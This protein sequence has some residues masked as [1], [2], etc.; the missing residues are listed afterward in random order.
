MNYVGKP[1]KRLN[2]SKFITGKSVYIDDLQISSLNA[3]FVRSP[4]AHARVK[5]VDA[6]DALKTKGIV[7]VFTAKDLNPMTS[8]GP[9]P[10][11]TYINQAEWKFVP[12][13]P[14]TEEA[15]Y[16]GDPVAI[17]IGIDKYSVRDAVDKVNV[18][19]EELPSAIALEDALKGEALVHK[20]LGT[21]VGYKKDFSAGNV[22]SA[23]KSADKVIPVEASNTRL[24]PSPMEPRG[25][26][27]RWEGGSLTVW[28]STQIP[29]FAR[30]E[31]SKD[32]GI[33]S[34]RIRVI[35]P[36]VGGA[37]GSK[38]HF[39]AED[40]AV[41]ASSIKLGRTVRWTATRS[42]E[43]ISSNARHNTFKGEVAV[44]RDGTILGIRGDLTVDLGA[45]LTYTEGLQP[46]IIPLMIPGPYKIRDILVRSTAVYTN[47]PPI[48]MY[49]GASRPEATFIIERIMSTVADELHMDDL[50]LREKNMVRADEMP[51]KNPF[52]L[53]YDSG[54]YLSFL[55]E[56]KEKLKYHETLT[57]A[58]AERTKGKRIGVG[59]AFY[60]EISGFGP[61]EYGEIRVDER[62]D[63]TVVTGGTPHGQGT[64]TAI[65]QVVADELQIDIGR[66][67]VVWG[68]TQVVASGMGSYGSRT[69]SI[70]GSAAKSASRQVLEK[71]KYVAAKMLNAD[72]EEVEYSSCEFKYKKEGKSVKWDE[73]AKAAYSG[74]DPGLYASVTLEGDVTYPYGLHMAIV[75][76]DDTGIVRVKE[77]RAYDDIGRVINPALAE[78]QIHG[79]AM[80]GVGQALYEEARIN[81]EGQLAV[82]YA[83]YFVPTIM[84]SPHYTSYFTDRPFPSNYA[85]GTKGVGEAA[86]IVGPAA[87]VRAIENATGKRFNKTPVTPEEVYKSLIK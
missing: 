43:L 31:F 6:S 10:W 35:M 56:A 81:D 28:Y 52:G 51:Y 26:V 69:I 84:E 3:A 54:D 44:K 12:R 24:I 27:S 74:K 7:A 80:Q 86:L 14:L 83:E 39:V 46:A 50:E 60:L 82:S 79:G 19:Y 72:V 59:T 38:A 87:I 65:A 32:F 62:G 30:E 11:V 47:T 67:N 13:K 36:D 15:R 4:Y 42:E 18:D 33:P 23:F 17:V 76:I 1:V 61:W 29:H 78:A 20:E 66:I 25:I 85:T 49:R 55:R 58:E 9:G 71:M 70:A 41:V 75:E 57:W 63:V 16:V 64:D 48:T 21:N 34:S 40:L 5:S 45:Y 37:F 2:D 53:V 8:D 77:Y 22:E 73:V 68:D